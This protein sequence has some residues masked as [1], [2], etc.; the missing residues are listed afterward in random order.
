[1]YK[2]GMRSIAS[3]PFSPRSFGLGRY[4]FLCVTLALLVAGCASPKG[5]LWPPP[6]NSSTGTV[7]VSLDVWHAVIGFTVDQ[8]SYREPSGRMGLAEPQAR[9]AG[10]PTNVVFE[11][12]AYAERG[13]YLEGRRGPAGIVRA[14]FWPTEGIVEVGRHGRLWAD[15]TP[16]PPATVYRFDVSEVGL[17]RLREHLRGTLGG[18][19]SIVSTPSSMFYPAARSYHLFHTCHQYAAEALREAGLPI[20][21][22]WAFSRSTLAMQLRRALEQAQEGKP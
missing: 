16:D 7:Y 18:A 2:A 1:M 19:E 3:E 14:L 9:G 20:T 22:F 8:S 12:W 15:R 10:T 13:W 21:P 17:H 6:E 11:E 5:D 4:H